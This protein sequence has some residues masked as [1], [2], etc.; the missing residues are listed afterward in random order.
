MT[1]S[2]KTINVSYTDSLENIF[3]MLLY[4]VLKDHVNIR[5]LT[6]KY[7]NVD[8]EIS[9]RTNENRMFLELK[10][11][12]TCSYDTFIIGANKIRQI[13]KKYNPCIIVW[14][15]SDG[16]YFCDCKKDF[17]NY[18]RKTIQNSDVI[19]INKRDCSVGVESL[20]NRIL[21]ILHITVV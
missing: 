12:T 20:K 18:T 3:A 5:V 16:I 4:S 6:D 17:D 2:L 1:V 19:E 7:S 9:A 13:N 11:R 21:D 10:S 15:F 8:Y 14:N